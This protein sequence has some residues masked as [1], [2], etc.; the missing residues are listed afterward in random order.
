MEAM[1]VASKLYKGPA[2]SWLCCPTDERRRRLPLQV[3][4]IVAALPIGC[5]WRHIRLAL[6]SF[7][8]PSSNS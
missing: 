1:E 4:R 5:N 8:F 2:I 7:Y 3:R 6:A